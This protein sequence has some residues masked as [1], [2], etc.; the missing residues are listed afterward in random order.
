MDADD[1]NNTQIAQ[2]PSP[3]PTAPVPPALKI[4]EPPPRNAGTSAPSKTGPGLMTVAPP[5]AIRNNLPARFKSDE[6]PSILE[7]VIKSATTK[8]AKGVLVGAPSIVALPGQAREF[9]TEWGVERPYHAL[10]GQKDVPFISYAEKGAHQRGETPGDW[11]SLLPGMIRAPT[12]QRIE[13]LV[14]ENFPPLAYEPSSAPG[15]YIGELTQGATSSAVLGPLKLPQILGRAVVG[16]VAGATAE[17]A[18]DAAK[19]IYPSAE[20]Y[21]RFLGALAPIALGPIAKNSVV[22]LKNAIAPSENFGNSTIWGAIEKDMR[23]AGT[24]AGSPL[25]YTQFNEMVLAGQ[26]VTLADI[27]GPETRKWIS[28]YGAKGPESEGLLAKINSQIKLR[29]E[30][31]KADIAETLTQRYGLTRTASEHKAAIDAANRPLIDAAYTLARELPAAQSIWTPRIG[32]LFSSNAFTNSVHRVNEL[33][34]IDGTG[35]LKSFSFGKFSNQIEGGAPAIRPN[36]AFWDAVKRD[37]DA[38]IRAAVSNNDDT[39]A[40]MLLQQKKILVAELDN[41]VPAYAKAR[42]AAAENFSA[43]NA[44]DAGYFSLGGLNGMKRGALIENFKKLSGED[45]ILFRQGAA[46]YLRDRL[47]SAQTSPKELVKILQN[48][49]DQGRVIFGDAEFS[50][51]IGNVQQ[52]ALLDKIKQITPRQSGQSTK[53]ILGN[54]AISAGAGAAA[55]VALSALFGVSLGGMTGAFMGAG[56]Y[57]AGRHALAKGEQT[58]ARQMLSLVSETDPQRLAA[59]TVKLGALLSSSPEAA[60]IWKT[61]QKRAAYAAMVSQRSSPESTEPQ[62]PPI[63]RAFGG[64]TGINHS[65]EASS[66]IRMAERAKKM[67]NATTATLLNQPDET[68]TRALAIADKAI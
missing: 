26:P 44:I 2:A 8:A 49:R 59:A 34:A 12:H 45:Q 29:A 60:G 46:D 47:K 6:E 56:A 39:L 21:A 52:R 51:I 65:A 41:A 3:A 33:A 25:T 37:I 40:P 22:S 13:R 1:F 64:R 63:Y 30:N 10:F 11:S 61:A 67:H 20:P 5:G 38:Q 4:D 58:L 66:L 17:A 24:V 9:I 57:G 18:G 27:A 31:S 54:S 23:S 62:H 42:N 19:A 32:G 36:L 28:L 55:E 14:N 16:G 53:T 15:R 43:T 7:D 68:I 50:Y 35:M 48:A